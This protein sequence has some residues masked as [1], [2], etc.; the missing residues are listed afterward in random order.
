M[1]RHSLD[2]AIRLADNIARESNNVNMMLRKQVGGKSRINTPRRH[3]ANG[4]KG[5]LRISRKNAGGEPS[6]QQMIDNLRRKLSRL[7][8]VNQADLV[9]SISV[10]QRSPASE[11]N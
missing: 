3:K 2:E 11:G 6:L 4:K 7:G 10:N 5:K 8:Y 9:S 1:A